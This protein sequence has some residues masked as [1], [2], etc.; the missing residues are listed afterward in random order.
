MT[1][2]VQEPMSEEQLVV[3]QAVYDRF[4]ERGTWTTFGDVDRPLRRLGLVPDAIVA[5]LAADLLLSF[6]A[7]RALPIARDELR[8]SLK[9]IAA[10]NGGQEDI[11]YFLRL[12]PW[13]AE[14]ELEFSPDDEHPEADLRVTVAEIREHLQL[15][16]DPA[17][18]IDRLR[19]LIDLQRWDWSNGEIQPGEWYVQVDRSIY[20]FAHV[21]TLD[22]YVD[23]IAK[24]EEEGKRS[25]AAIPVELF[26][27]AFGYSGTEYQPEPPADTYVSQIT[28]A[29][30]EAATEQSTLN[31]GKLLRLIAELNDDYTSGRAYSAHAMLRALLDHVPPILGCSDFNAVANNY[32]WSLT[33]KR[34]MKRLVEFRVQADDV[35][36]RQISKQADVL[37]IEDMP[38]RAAIN[39]LL[40]LCADKLQGDPTK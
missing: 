23:V 26:D 39:I 34:Y 40:Q 27:P 24:W 35:L 38:Q 25:Y 28:V 1:M 33:D 29:A 17:G 13:L 30:I 11:D 15:L 36:H 3:L 22:D 6:D 9:G 37:D 10:C 31:C 19:R 16:D 14:R 2:T 20:R 8:L 18:V 7:S 12:V 5:T 21:K 4:C 32:G